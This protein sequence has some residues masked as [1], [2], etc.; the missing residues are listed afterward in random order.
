MNEFLK[1]ILGL[2][3]LFGI[4]GVFALIFY[5]MN[6]ENDDLRNE[7]NGL[8]EQIAKQDSATINLYSMLDESEKLIEN[9]R[10]ET[11]ECPPSYGYTLNGRSISSNELLDILLETWKERDSLAGELYFKT[12]LI[13]SVEKQWGIEVFQ[14]KDG[15]G[16]TL[17]KGSKILNDQAKLAD[18]EFILRELKRRY[19]LNYEIKNV[20]QG[21]QFI[22]P[23]NRIDSALILYPYF[24][25]RLKRDKNDFIITK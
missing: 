20:N 22:M 25:D 12:E 21:Q 23:F 6:S 19:P 3:P 5:F 11:L 13:K 1:K 9:L 14:D 7:I 2:L 4:I 24:K 10:N 15:Y 16:L 8:N 18:L 17:S